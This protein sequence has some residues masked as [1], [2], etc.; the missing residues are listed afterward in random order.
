MKYS[1]AS[2][3]TL[4]KDFVNDNKLTYS[5]FDIL[6]DFLGEEEQAEVE[7]V[8]N[9]NGITLTDDCAGFI[10]AGFA[11][12]DM[13]A[14]VVNRGFIPESN[15]ELCRLISRGSRQALQ[16]IIVKN[17]GLVY[18]YAK[19]FAK[20]FHNDL[21]MEDLM[22]AGRG[23]I[24]EAARRFRPEVGTLF[25]TYATY[26]ISQSI[27][28]EAQTC[29]HSIHIPCHIQEAIVKLN[30]AAADLEVR[31]I[32]TDDKMREIAEVMGLTEQRARELIKVRDSFLGSTSLDRPMSEDSDHTLGEFIT[33]DP[34][35]VFN[36]IFERSRK[37]ILAKAISS[38]T[39]REA[40]VICKRFG[41][42]GGNGETLEAVGCELNV[43][44]ERV[45]QIEAKALRKLYRFL[46]ADKELLGFAA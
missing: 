21:D 2:I 38:L 19:K 42:G 9:L 10:G 1:V 8:L 35:P 18:K 24:L 27:R 16:D 29:G 43:T 22:Q 33:N 45:R 3:M 37:D 12:M 30:H 17:E 7:R 28:R 46:K 15:E 23:G 40:L 32:S 25:T 5:E 11:G 34:D 20:Y 14:P 39:E 41:I 36:E 6:F 4:V 44:R 26:W 13:N 31:G